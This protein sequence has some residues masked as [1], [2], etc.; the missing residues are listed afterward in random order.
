MAWPKKGTR[1]LTIN[2][3]VFLWHYS[4]HCPLCSED[5]FTIGQ[6]GQRFVLY[7]D[8]VPWGFELTPSSVVKAVK[9][10]LEQGWTTTVGP[11]RGMAWN[12]KTN[13]FQWLPDGNRHLNCDSKLESREQA[14]KKYGSL[15]GNDEWQS[16][17]G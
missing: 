15:D 8:P 2:K 6:E 3:E 17:N 14:A 4:A 7:I 9:W 12:D 5:V 16:E 11:T 10:A 1:R 13:G